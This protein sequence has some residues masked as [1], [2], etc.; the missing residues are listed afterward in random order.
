MHRALAD[1]ATGLVATHGDLHVGQ[2]L[3]DEHGRLF[4][5]DFDGNPTLTPPERV[6]HRP[7]A[8]D[9]AG[10]LVVAGERRARRRAPPPR[11]HRRS[12]R[13]VDR[14]RAGGVPGRLPRGGRRRSSTRRCS[15][16]T[17]TTRS[18]ASSTTP[19]PTSPAG[20]TCRRR[21]CV[22]EDDDEPGP[23]PGRSG[24]EARAAPRLE[25]AW[26]LG[27]RHPT[28]TGRA[29]R[30]GLLPLRRPGRGRPTAGGRGRRGGRAGQQR[31]APRDPPPTTWSWPCRR[32]P[33]RPRPSTPSSGSA[34]TSSRW[35]T[36][37]ARS[38]SAATRTVWM[39]AGEER[40]GVACRSYQHTLALLLALASGT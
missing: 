18:S 7:A 19:T 4:V 12:R 25:A 32:R 1:P 13:G 33:A 35:P 11:G 20:A 16:R 15:S 27:F 2:V 38:P 37:R 3:R 28:A 23:V 36:S 22:G 17:S 29:A 26:R 8:Y 5:I 30:H 10:L 21:R 31:P 6:L 40:G 34:S 9:V 14:R 24:G 39:E